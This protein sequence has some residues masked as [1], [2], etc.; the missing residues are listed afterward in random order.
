MN[1]AEEPANGDA[2]APEAPQPAAATPA[3]PPE[4]GRA[5]AHRRAEPRGFAF[6]WTCYLLGCTVIAIGQLGRVGLT[7]YDVYRP[8]AKLL[9]TLVLAGIAIFWPLVRLSQETP[10]RPLRSFFADSIVVLSPASAI[11]V[12]QSLPGMAGWSITVVAAVIAFA[13]AWS[14][15]L[16]GVLALAVGSS[17]S[18]WAWMLAVVLLSCAGPGMGILLGAGED[19]DET[20]NPF[21][22]TSPLT[23]SYEITRDRSW[24]G[25][26]AETQPAH[27]A[28]IGAV[29]GLGIMAVAAAAF[30][31]DPVAP[32]SA[33]A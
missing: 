19:E 20:S 9:L 12:S 7:S 32:G 3:P 5:L 26:T 25:V 14:L 11:I 33:A 17:A 6:L 27:W 21:L 30:R 15:L 28:A 22:L 23:V 24:A 31:K 1:P 8:A 4:P 18:R 10:G 16:C 2:V 29:G 13:A